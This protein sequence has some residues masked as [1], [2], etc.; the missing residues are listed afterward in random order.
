MQQGQP[1]DVS[2]YMNWEKIVAPSGAVGY[3]VPETGLVY[4]PFMSKTKGRNVFYQNSKPQLEAQKKAEQERERQVKLQEQQASP[5]GQLL[6]IAGGVGGLVA[7]KGIGNWMDK[8]SFFGNAATE[9]GKTAGTVAS[10]GAQTA[11]EAFVGGV[12]EVGSVFFPEAAA[13]A[14]EA[15]TGAGTFFN[16]AGEVPASLMSGTPPVA[17]PAAGGFANAFSLQG[18]GTQ[19]N[20]LLPAAGAYGAYDL[21]NRRNGAGRG[22]LQGAASGAAIGSTFGP[23]GALIGAGIGGA[24]GLAESFF[25]DPSTKELEKERWGG[26][27]DKGIK[28]AQAAYLANHPPGDTSIY[29]EGPRKGEKWKFENA[30][31]DT[32]KD[33]SHFR[34]VF[35]NYDTFGN[36]WSSY[37][38]EQQD[39]IVSRLAN[40]NLYSGRKGDVVINDKARA[41]QI[42]D[43]VLSGQ[44]TTAVTPEVAVKT[45]GITQKPVQEMVRQPFIYGNNTPQLPA[46]TNMKG[47]QEI[48]PAPQPAQSVKPNQSSNIGREIARQMNEKN[49]KR[50]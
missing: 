29:Q 9:A 41:R 20:L 4:D 13:G 39:Q 47:P 24:V 12:P 40:E 30:L 26:L 5:L 10:T 21:F 38:P 42:K 27:A 28:D 37:T 15:A 25:D 7:A 34:L 2:N 3:I 14:G 43:E 48:I 16:T 17:P 45:Q 11:G 6:P 46:N 35:G 31:E 44:N 49:K 33:P 23:T 32:K 50:R 22:A 1:I 19:G 8:G 18:I 36:D